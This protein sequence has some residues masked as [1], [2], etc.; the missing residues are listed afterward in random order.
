[1]VVI[2]KTCEA[3]PHV[4]IDEFSGPAADLSKAAESFVVIDEGGDCFDGSDVGEDGSVVFGFE[5]DD[6]ILVLVLL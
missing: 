3:F 2:P 4:I 1:M 5:D 6:L